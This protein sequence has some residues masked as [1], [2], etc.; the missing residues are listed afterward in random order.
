MAAYRACTPVVVDD[1][2]SSA[3]TLVAT[4][5]QLVS[6]GMRAPVCVAVH[7]LFSH[8]A[9]EALLSAGAGKVVTTTSVPHPT[10]AIDVVPLM[11]EPIRQMC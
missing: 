3:R 4:V 1:V 5:E 11:I 2:V 8:T 6:A 10:N 9:E 7:G